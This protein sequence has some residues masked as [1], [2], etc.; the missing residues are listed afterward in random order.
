MVDEMYANVFGRGYGQEIVG[1]RYF[2][3]F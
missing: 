3:V 2:N 1:L